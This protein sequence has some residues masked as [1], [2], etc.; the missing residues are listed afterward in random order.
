M[1]RYLVKT[2]GEMLDQ[3]CLA[4]YGSTANYTEMV[5]AA[6]PGLSFQ[7]EFVPIGTEILLP[8]IKQEKSLD[9]QFKSLWD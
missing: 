8:E 3:I 9:T 5:L 1:T 6:N 2:A 4:H 7:G